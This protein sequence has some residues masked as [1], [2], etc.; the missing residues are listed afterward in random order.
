M[1]RNPRR[2]A[3]RGASSLELAML[4]PLLVAVILLVVQFALVYHA[5]HVALA[6]AQDGA[7]VARGDDTAG[8][9]TSAEQRARK[10]VLNYG[11]RLLGEPQV[12][13]GGDGYQRW[14]EVRGKAVEVIPGF[15]FNVTKRAGG[16]R[17]CFRP[18][19]GEGTQCE[20]P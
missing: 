4:T 12:T 1:S 5:Q 8:W 10:S 7:R 18:D 11:P 2:P 13:V 3:D 17:E 16:P 9:Q 20:N 6:A 15:K 19:V 14:V